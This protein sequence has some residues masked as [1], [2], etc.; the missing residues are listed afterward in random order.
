MSTRASLLACFLIAGSA[1]G[2]PSGRYVTQLGQRVLAL[3]DKVALGEISAIN[4]PFRGV[5]TARVS[6]AEN[7]GG[8]DLPRE[9]LTL[10]YISDYLAPDAIRSTFEEGSI[11]FSPKRSDR[12]RRAAESLEESGGESRATGN[13]STTSG[14]KTKAPSTPGDDRG[15]QGVRF[16]KGERGIF[17]LRKR[18]ASYALIGFIPEHDPLYKRKLERLKKVLAIEAISSRDGRIRAARSIYIQSLKAKDVWERGN[19]AREIEYMALQFGGA[20]DNDARLYLA[21]RLYNEKNPTI[22][23]ALERAVRSVAPDEAVAYAVDAEE[24]ERKVH[25]KA[26]AKEEKYLAAN[27]IVELRAAELIRIA[28]TYGRAATQ[29]LCNNLNDPDALVRESAA[30]A[31]ARDGGPSCRPLLRKALEVEKN[32]DAA[33]AMIHTLGVKS[34]PEALPLIAKRLTNSELE[35]AAVQAVGRI[36]TAD[37][38][39]ILRRHRNSASAPSRAIIDSILADKAGT[40]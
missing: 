9:S 6:I 5:T 7:L 38:L 10:M 19:A 14:T 31:L 2:A 13:T 39:K 8:L 40:R 1:F 25:A 11:T 22:A 16:L 3:C 30:G 24:R 23:A 35:Q 37:A 18:G 4:P 26:L 17:F 12:L 27:K 28:N 29:L 15:E 32:D 20:F 34:D 36:G 33:R 21:E